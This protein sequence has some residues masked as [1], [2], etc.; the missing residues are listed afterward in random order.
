MS[1]KSQKYHFTDTLIQLEVLY[2]I[3]MS[4]GTSL[5]LHEMLK[6][7]LKVYL[8]KL[9][10][11]SGI[12]LKRVKTPDRIE[13]RP[14]FAIPRNALNQKA[15]QPAMDQI[16]NG[17]TQED[18]D[19]FLNRLPITGNAEKKL[20]YYIM[21]LVDFGLLIL[22]KKQPSF[23]LFFL[24]S[25]RQVNQK[26]AWSCIACEQ[27]ARIYQVNT[28]LTKE[29]AVRK[30]T[31]SRLKQ[32]TSELE[33]RV[34]QRTEE[35]NKAN[36]EL[37][38][39]IETL[40]TTQIGLKTSEEKY[41]SVMEAT[42]DPVIVYDKQGRVLYLNPSF[43]RI[44]G[45]KLE[46]LI[47][48]RIDFVPEECKKETMAAVKMAM[49]LGYV[50]DFESRRITKTG[51]IL[52]VSVSAA[53]YRNEVGKLL[54]IVV[55]IRDMT[56]L[57][58]TRQLMIQTEKM[59]SVGGLAAGMAHEINNPLAGILQNS[60]VIQN[61]LF[62]PMQANLTIAEKNQLSFKDMSGYLNDRKIPKL[63][64]NI[65]ASGTQA[66]KIVEDMLSFS[67]KDQDQFKSIAMDTLIDQALELGRHDFDLSK[68]YDFKSILIAK[69]YPEAIPEIFCVPNQI[70]QV[71]FNILKNAAYAMFHAEDVDRA[72]QIIFRVNTSESWVI[73]EIEDNGPGMDD[74]VQKRIFEPFF[75][76]KPVGQGTGLGLSVAY[77]IITDRHRGML[78]VKSE[79]GMR[80]I[81]EIRLPIEGQL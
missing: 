79:L 42:P 70:Q 68:K 23:E 81:F 64:E 48:K 18:F 28:Q 33:L 43:S 27:N 63:L 29:V 17:F 21:N 51:E 75:T 61:R 50:S 44:F 80:T 7:S 36:E 16:S 62:E 26:L 11:T 71:L 15:C 34:D 47:N 46:E 19:L 31:E 55:N 52:E 14:E 49:E 41:R 53:G 78:S 57:K 65:M 59:I 58:K 22:V 24:K 40:N 10:C 76:T 66:A 13:F 54:G 37:K 38:E 32:I 39:K 30:A 69:E 8:R 77:F 73:L 45:W 2:E 4:I 60:Q 12:V 67:R 74:E 25:L 6:T 9:N 5:D 72:P 3:A 1:S 35:L 20:D 56:E